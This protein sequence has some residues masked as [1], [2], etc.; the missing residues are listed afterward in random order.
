MT[1]VVSSPESLDAPVR[2]HNGLTIPGDHVADGAVD[3]ALI[4]SDQ[5][6]A[7]VGY[8]FLAALA[9]RCARTPR[10]PPA[11]PEDGYWSRNF[12]ES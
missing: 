2:P 7:R 11:L 10:R 6:Q 1:G 9:R 8:I 4:L 12:Y 3:K 5:S